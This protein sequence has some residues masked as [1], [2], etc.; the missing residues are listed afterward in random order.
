MPLIRQASGAQRVVTASAAAFLLVAPFP[1]SAGWRVFFLLVAAG[2]LAWQAWR[3]T[4]PLDL[5][6]IPRFFAIAALAWIAL[7]VVSLAWSVDPGYT[8]DELR[9]EIAYGGLAFLVLFS[10]TRTPRDLHAG[11]AMLFAGAFLL[12]VGEWLRFLLPGVA[13][14]RKASMGPGPYSTQVVL[15]APLLVLLAWPRPVG[16]ERGLRVTL[17]VGV[18]LVVAGIASDSRILW[19]ALMVSAVVAFTAFWIETPA[20]HPG[21]AAARRMLI[22]AL[23]LLPML[24][25]VAT[26]YKLRYYPRAATSMEAF[27][28]DERPLIWKVASSYAR[29][30]P[31]L[32]YGY[33]REIIGARISGELEQAKLGQPYN[34]GHNVVLDAELQM[35]VPGV[36]AFIL[37]M[38]SLVAAFLRARK[39]EGGVPLAI[40]GVAMVAGYLTKNLTDDFFF[41]PSSLVFWAIA[42]MLLGLAARLP[43]KR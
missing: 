30:R 10:A 37:L 7:C 22:A 21:R 34:H 43:Q 29:E 11:I 8:L 31:W 15:L 32:G 24:M 1:S 3:G 25:V 9:R 18:A 4:Q 33:G 41:R 23:V 39:R 6:R 36:I 26:E 13:W 35:G 17:A 14:A 38:A 42:G 12:G 19:V 27:S 28:F 2:A 40:V 5:T 20:D 16:L